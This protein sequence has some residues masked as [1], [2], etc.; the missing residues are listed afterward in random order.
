MQSIVIEEAT[1]QDAAAIAALHALSWQNTY[2]GIYSDA[3]LD[4]EVVQERLAV[5]QNRFASPNPSQ[6]VYKAMQENTIIGFVCFYVNVEPQY[7]TF[8]DNLH[9]TPQLKGQGIGKKL[10]QKVAHWTQ[11]NQPIKGMY[12]WVLEENKAALGFYKK[13]GAKMAERKIE[14]NQDG[15]SNTILR[16]VWE[17]IEGLSKLLGN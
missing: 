9:V 12:L 17:G 13:C 8:V 7:G 2:R 14:A 11:E 6:F 5:W 10:L 3:F 16:S 1:P 4:N 15:E